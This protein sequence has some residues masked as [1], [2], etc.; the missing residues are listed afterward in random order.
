MIDLVV[1]PPGSGGSD[2]G[3][4]KLNE[5]EVSGAEGCSLAISRVV[6]VAHLASQ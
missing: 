6:Q 4:S 1:L 2:T 5:Q 3:G